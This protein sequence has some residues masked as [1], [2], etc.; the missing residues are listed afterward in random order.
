MLFLC[1]LFFYTTF[2]FFYFILYPFFFSIQ[3]NF[4]ILHYQKKR[5]QEGP[6][7][8]FLFS[9]TTRKIS[10]FIMRYF[11]IEEEK[12]NNYNSSKS[13]GIHNFKLKKKE[14]TFSLLFLKIFST[15]VFFTQK[16]SPET[17]NPQSLSTKHGYR[18]S[19][20][21]YAP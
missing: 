9:S 4:H 13:F 15:S 3:N 2:S 7:I 5:Q 19:P 16:T 1:S 20:W 11:S 6:N 12:I 18:L 8:F 10:T 17:K 21:W 14:K